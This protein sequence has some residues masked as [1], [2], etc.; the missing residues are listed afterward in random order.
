M[1]HPGGCPMCQPACAEAFT[2][3]SVLWRSELRFPSWEREGA[4]SLLLPPTANG[5]LGLGSLLGGDVQREQ[6]CPLQGILGIYGGCFGLSQC[7]GKLLAISG[8]GHI[9]PA[10]HLVPEN[11]TLQRIH[12]H[13]PK[14]FLHVSLE[15]HASEKSVYSYVYLDANSLS[16]SSIYPWIYIKKVILCIGLKYTE[17]SRNSATW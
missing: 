6:C 15:M 5:I 1:V 10:Y 17:L 13:L 14:Q 4:V 8:W 7:L 11:S 12:L 2:D 16:L 9:C 3:T